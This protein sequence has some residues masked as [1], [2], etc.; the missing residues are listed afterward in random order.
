MT[1]ALK[2]FVG[3]VIPQM[4]YGVELWGWNQKLLER[5]EIFQ[6]FYLRRILGLPQSTPAALL[7]VE[8]GLPSVSARAHLRFLRFFTN[9]I[10]APNTLLAKQ[11]FVSLQN[12]TTWHKSLSDILSRYNLPELNTLKLWSADK[13]REWI[14]EKDAFMDS[15][16]IKNSGF[17]YWLP[18]V[19][20]V[21][22]CANYLVEITD[23]TLRRA[24]TMA[25]FQTLPTAYLTGRYTKTPV[26]HRLCPCLMRIK[27]DLTHYFLYCPIYSGFRDALLQIIP[28]SITSPEDRVKFLL[29]DA[30]PRITHV[31]AVF[32]MKAMKARERFMDDNV[33][34]PSSSV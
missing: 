32:V 2:T 17:S 9:L 11:A 24:F 26:E 13:V 34:T 27:E 10:D 28:N 19:K 25:R 15:T 21:K 29:V 4:F 22:I 6:N 33:K 3:K 8:V 14:F 12:N 18:Q 23:P 1:P 16:K 7:R 31:V 5:L 20:A 30:N